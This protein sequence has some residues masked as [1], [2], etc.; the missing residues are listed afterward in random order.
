MTTHP[1]AS[2]VMQRAEAAAREFLK[3]AQI[4][5][6]AKNN[7]PELAAIIARHFED[8]KE[9]RQALADLLWHVETTNPEQSHWDFSARARAALAATAPG[10]K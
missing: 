7:W 1:S 4:Y 5:P 8:Y 9:M 6:A 10:N 2:D 3:D